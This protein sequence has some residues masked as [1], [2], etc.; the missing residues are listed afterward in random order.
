VTATAAGAEVAAVEALDL[1]DFRCFDS[2]QIRLAAGMT[3]LSGP[4]GEGKT[5]VLEAVAWAAR[6]RSFRRV[7]DSALVRAGAAQA[8]LRCEI[9]AGERRRLVEAELRPTTGT[10]V[11]VDR[12]P[13]PRRRDLHDVLRVTIFSP[14]DLELVKGAPAERREYL[15]ELVGSISPRCDAARSELERVLRQ[16]NA[17]LKLRRLDADGLATLDVF[18]AQL[19]RAGAVLVQ[20]RLALIERLS[21]ALLD[22]YA[23]LSGHR[24]TVSTSYRSEWFTGAPDREA[25]EASLLAALEESRGRELDRG[26]TAVGPQRDEWQL[27]IDGRE[28]R[29]QASQGEQR[30]LALALRLAGHA[31]VRDVTGVTPVLLLDD[32]FSE[33]D[34]V[35]S[36]ALVTLLPPGQAL[37]T[38]AARLPDAVTPDQVLRLSGHRLVTGAAA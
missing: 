32:V 6:G 22:A 26:A 21:G 17:L 38:T 31:V 33:L 13:L 24:C 16:R 28:A 34:P 12:H 3:V 9:A 20:G 14:D 30:S 37:L 19:A 4:N 8:V 23:D 29:A 2:I 7:P 36:D 27:A 10:R 18:D 1:T 35:R 15:D 11:R 25:L 5:S